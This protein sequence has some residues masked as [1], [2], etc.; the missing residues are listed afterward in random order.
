MLVSKPHCCASKNRWQIYQKM[1]DTVSVMNKNIYD[2][3]VILYKTIDD[4]VDGLSEVIMS[5]LVT[6]VQYCHQHQLN[7]LISWKT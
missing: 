2:K 1:D 4:K 7:R 5:E 3:V 6:K